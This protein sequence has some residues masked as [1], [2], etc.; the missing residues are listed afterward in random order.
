MADE[1]GGYK[2]GSGTTGLN[3]A[4]DGAVLP[5]HAAQ[6][7]PH[8]QFENVRHRPL[9]EIWYDSY[10]FNA[11][12]GTG[13]LP[14][15]CQNCDRRDADTGGGR[16]EAMALAGDAGVTD[17][18]CVKSSHHAALRACAAAHAAGPDALIYRTAAGSPIPEFAG[19]G[20]E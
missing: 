7:I 16:C 9:S 19:A 18:A 5:C 11:Y 10:A 12:R 17:P 8:L 14:E 1:I 20:A 3:V 4:P 13:W 6:T 2:G 15:P